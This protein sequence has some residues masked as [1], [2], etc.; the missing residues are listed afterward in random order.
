MA[1]L[2]YEDEIKKLFEI[3]RKRGKLTEEEIG[4]TLLSFEKNAD[5]MQSLM[6]QFQKAGIE[7]IKTDEVRKADNKLIEE[8]IDQLDTA[9]NDPVK[10]YLKDIGKVP[11]LS[12]PE[13]IELASKMAQGDEKAKE[14]LCEANLRLVVSVAKR[15]VGRN[16][17]GKASL[18][19]LDLIQEGNMGLMKAVEKFD[20]SRGFR[21]STYATWWIKQAI[22]RAKADQARMIRLPVHMVET[23]SKVSKVE[24]TL[25]QELNRDPTPEEIANVMGITAQ[26][27]MEIKIMAQD[28]VSGHQPY[29]DKDESTWFDVYVDPE[30]VSPYKHT[31][32]EM[33][34][35]QLLEIINSLT[36]REQ[37]VVRLRYG[38]DDGKP[39]TLE[40]VGKKF[41]V[42]RER[43]RQIEAKALRK[44]RHP[45]R[46]KKLRDFVEEDGGEDDEN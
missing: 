30:S 21:F 39:R 14:K 31:E 29:N 7:I 23:I 22:S 10:M 4:Q 13:E 11:L 26:R 1:R 28:P 43:I 9:V 34:R 3:G 37:S 32:Q 33:L 19:F 17:L 44:L 15:H 40:E 24:K 45:N 20:P 38:L 42:T 18:S 25:Q 6:E 12:G 35:V 5:E 16:A 2:V 27:V 36:P 41:N 8:L 46:S